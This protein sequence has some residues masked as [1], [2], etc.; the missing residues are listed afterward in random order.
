[1]A[2]ASPLTI[3]LTLDDD[4]ASE[5][6]EPL[7]PPAT[8][9]SA[10]PAKSQSKATPHGLTSKSYSDG[11]SA[12]PT[13]GTVPSLPLDP[14]QEPHSPAARI[15][16]ASSSCVKRRSIAEVEA[17]IALMEEQAAVRHAK[18]LEDIK[19]AELE[20]KEARLQR[21]L[22]FYDAAE[23]H[24]S[25]E[26]V[27]LVQFGAEELQKV[28][29][30]IPGNSLDL[31]GTPGASKRNSAELVSVKQLDVEGG[32]QPPGVTAEGCG[33][34]MQDEPATADH[35]GNITTP[36]RCKGASSYVGSTTNR[37]DA[38]ESDEENPAKRR[39]VSTHTVAHIDATHINSECIQSARFFGE[40]H[41]GGFVEKDSHRYTEDRVEFKRIKNAQP[42]L[43]EL[44]YE[45]CRIAALS[46][47]LNPSLP[48]APGQHG[49]MVRA[50]R[51]LMP[52]GPVYEVFV[53]YSSK[54]G[55]SLWRYYGQYTFEHYYPV[56]WDPLPDA[57]KAMWLNHLL[58]KTW[59]R[60]LLEENNV[61]LTDT[62]ARDEQKIIVNAALEAKQ[63]SDALDDLDDVADAAQ[64]S[65]ERKKV[66]ED[67]KATMASRPR[68]L[69]DALAELADQ[70]EAERV[71]LKLRKRKR[72]REAE[73]E[74]VRAKMEILVD[75]DVLES[76]PEFQALWS[77]LQELDLQA[78]PVRK[79]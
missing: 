56:L 62:F 19:R 37:L 50:A 32:S 4:D 73:R 20:R 21:E 33:E 48:S 39:R 17:R 43:Q 22:A 29:E 63:A 31:H 65:K 41:A 11:P 3:D 44:K 74:R 60:A 57:T 1:M 47:T 27:F 28:R 5:A 61:D 78:Q 67:A 70:E 35:R 38:D 24:V 59:G 14:K 76:G 36:K 45:T 66:M 13:S 55:D 30:G 15:G 79:T 23:S 51:D 16:S 77:R 75:D 12:T 49:S 52:T 10:L 71:K 8:G 6:D 54:R 72:D 46:R 34:G 7:R 18:Y 2:P 9:P 53:Q 26:E 42:L 25:D 69:T 58:R 68:H 40:V 64:R